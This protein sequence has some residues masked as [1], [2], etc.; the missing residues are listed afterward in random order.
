MLATTKGYYL[1]NLAEVW[2]LDSTYG[3]KHV[4]PL[5]AWASACPNARFIAVLY[6]KGSRA[7]HGRAIT[8]TTHSDS[9]RHR[10]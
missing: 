4:R 9:V 3:Q 1:A 7:I 8:V 10:T 6:T 2:A 5:D